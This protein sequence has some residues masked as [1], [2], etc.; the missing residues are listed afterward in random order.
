V[1]R[2]DVEHAGIELNRSATESGVLQ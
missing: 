1:I 2:N